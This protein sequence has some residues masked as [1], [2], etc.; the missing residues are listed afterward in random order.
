MW[1]GILT[2]FRNTYLNKLKS[3]VTFVCVLHSLEIN[4]LFNDFY[5]KKKKNT[6]HTKYHKKD[7]NKVSSD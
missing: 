4:N 1:A 7:K 3:L 6:S 5:L 2:I